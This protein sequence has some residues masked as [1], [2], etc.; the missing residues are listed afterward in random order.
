MGEQ[1]HAFWEHSLL[2]MAPVQLFSCV[3]E[4]DSSDSWVGQTIELEFLKGISCHP[5]CRCS[6]VPMFPRA[7]IS[8]SLVP[9]FPR[10]TVPP[11]HCSLVPLSF[12]SCRCHFPRAIVRSLR[13]SR[14]VAIPP[15]RC[16]PV[17]L[18]FPSC[19]CFL[20]TR[21]MGEQWHAFWE[22]SLLVMAPV[23]LFYCV[24]EADSSDSWVGQS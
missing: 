7:D 9:M 21:P 11:C 20:I 23:Q 8:R 10:A 4:A 17:P 5:L 3:T 19:H 18:S 12:P 6:L 16:S 24:T 1:R 22:H 14:R 15:C 13:R 2:V